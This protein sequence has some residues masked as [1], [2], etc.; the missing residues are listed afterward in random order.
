MNLKSTQ[1]KKTKTNGSNL[2]EYES[3]TIENV[4]HSNLNIFYNKC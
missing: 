2:A 1:K 3:Y 4:E